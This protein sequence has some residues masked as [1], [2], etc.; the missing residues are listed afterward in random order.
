ML[1]DVF[2]PLSF[3]KILEII[4]SPSN[5]LSSNENSIEFHIFKPE[6]KKCQAPHVTQLEKVVFVDA[7]KMIGLKPG[8]N[9]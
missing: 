5:K 1:N 6:E 2:F 8:V 4:W 7:K 3:E 9:L